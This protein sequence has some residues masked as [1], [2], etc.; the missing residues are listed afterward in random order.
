VGMDKGDD[1]L[2]LMPRKKS[3]YRVQM[4]ANVGKIRVHHYT[5]MNNAAVS[6]VYASNRFCVFSSSL[7]TIV[8]K[9][10]SN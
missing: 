10:H 7:C 1:E 5:Q 6:S 9:K 2:L 4:G 8:C 3:N